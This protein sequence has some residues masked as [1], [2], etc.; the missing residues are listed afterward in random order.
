MST[1]LVIE[2]EPDIQENLADLLDA[3][4]YDTLIA[5]DGAEGVERARKHQPDLILCDVMMPRL[6]GFEVLE[7]VR[8]DEA[9][10]GTP[11]IFLTAKSEAR[12][13]R[14]G[15]TTGADD[16]LTKPF[17]AVELFA[18]VET[19]LER[20]GQLQRKQEQRMTELQQSIS[21][22]IPHE[23]RTPLVAIEGFASLL[24]EDWATL[25]EEQAKDMLGEVLGAT[26][27]LKRLVERNALFAQV[28]SQSA[29]GES[30][31]GRTDVLPLIRDR[32]EARAA[33]HDRAADLTVALQPGE[34]RLPPSLLGGLIEEVV[35]N[36]FKFSPAGSPVHVT[37]RPDGDRYTLAVTD[38]GRGMRADQIQEVNAY[39][40]FGRDLHE[41]QGTGLGLALSQQICAI[42]GGTLTIDS[43]PDEGTTVEM[44]VPVAVPDAN[45]ESGLAA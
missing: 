1:I 15:M 35:D 20:F 41:Q 5:A 25:E 16:Y 9:L 13:L 12:D 38:E 2:D 32:A 34:V 21:Q 7:R 22:V 19:R 31:E 28:T 6:N 4:G 23:L 10:S 44:A 3:A 36:A 27:R 26:E 24:K 14:R 29:A 18:A 33:A 8:S 43:M 40:Q 30:P 39:R 11:F 42:A 45:L 17:Q 37:G